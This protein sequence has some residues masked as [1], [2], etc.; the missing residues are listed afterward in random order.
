[1]QPAQPVLLSICKSMWRLG[2][3]P[4]LEHIDMTGSMLSCARGFFSC[5]YGGR[6]LLLAV[7]SMRPDQTCGAWLRDCVAGRHGGSSRLSMSKHFQQ[8]CIPLELN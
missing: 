4:W 1:M 5:L 2:W 7:G 6:A 8:G 3:M